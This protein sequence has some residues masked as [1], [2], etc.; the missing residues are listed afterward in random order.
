M[1]ETS[2]NPTHILTEQDSNGLCALTYLSMG[3]QVG[4]KS[5]MTNL[6]DFFIMNL[7]N[8]D[9]SLIENHAKI[10]QQCFVLSLRYKR[11]KQ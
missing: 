7:N 10:I 5:D 8:E 1:L 9:V 6:L 3:T 4:Q 11:M 2:Q